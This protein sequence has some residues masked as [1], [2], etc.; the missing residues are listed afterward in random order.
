MAS[1][2]AYIEDQVGRTG[3]HPTLIKLRR[4]LQYQTAAFKVSTPNSLAPIS[5]PTSSCPV[6]HTPCTT[7]LDCPTRLSPATPTIHPTTP[8]HIHTPS[9]LSPAPKATPHPLLVSGSKNLL[10]P[11]PQ[12][13]RPQ[14]LCAGLGPCPL[15]S[16]VQSAHEPQGH[17]QGCL[18]GWHAACCQKEG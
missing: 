16:R 12:C 14:C 10:A 7:L 13:P 15:P 11:I 6:T 18:D 8:T 3:T 1:Y 17:C 5:G 9:P 2:L 4:R